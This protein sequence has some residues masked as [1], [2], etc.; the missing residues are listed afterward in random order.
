[1]GKI[2]YKEFSFWVVGH[3]DGAKP[4]IGVGLKN[5]FFSRKFVRMHKFP[6]Y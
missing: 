2:I 5:K 3:T 6:F 4:Q 1:M